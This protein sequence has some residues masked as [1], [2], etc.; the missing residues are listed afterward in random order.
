MLQVIHAC[1]RV[2][3]PQ[4]AVAISYLSSLSWAEG[5][6]GQPLPVDGEEVV[7]AAQEDS[8]NATLPELK[9]LMAVHDGLIAAVM[10]I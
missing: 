5:K 9:A 3:H 10:Q 7:G 2:K 4:V 8:T 6:D 1:E